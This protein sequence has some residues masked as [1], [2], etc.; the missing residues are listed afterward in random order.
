[1]CLPSHSLP[2]FLRLQASG[3]TDCIYNLDLTWIWTLS[4]AVDRSGELCV[5]LLGQSLPQPLPS[6]IQGFEEFIESGSVPVSDVLFEI[7]VLQVPGLR[8]KLMNM[9]D[10][11]S[12]LVSEI[13]ACINTLPPPPGR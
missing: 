4:G 12:L 13:T 9:G 3:S 1:M 5:R 6:S 7:L 11:R 2:C 8:N 10:D